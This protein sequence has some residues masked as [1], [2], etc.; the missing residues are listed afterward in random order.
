MISGHEMNTGFSVRTLFMIALLTSGNPKYVAQFYLGLC[1][2]LTFPKRVICENLT[3]VV[4]ARPAST[5]IRFFDLAL[6]APE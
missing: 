4:S 1:K 2:A 3:Q 5:R 6:F